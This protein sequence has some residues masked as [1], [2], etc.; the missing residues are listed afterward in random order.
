MPRLY[1]INYAMILNKRKELSPQLNASFIPMELKI[2]R[3]EGVWVLESRRA[4]EK[5]RATSENIEKN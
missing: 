3:I 2:M 4:V 5:V 1:V